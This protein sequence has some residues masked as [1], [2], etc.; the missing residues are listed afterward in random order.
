MF[1]IRADRTQTDELLDAC[2]PRL[3]DELYPHDGVVIEETPRMKPVRTDSAYDGRCMDHHV[4]TLLG[5]K[6]PNGGRV[7]KV[8]LLRR[9]GKN[10]R[11]FSTS[12]SVLNEA[13]QEAATSRQEDA[14]VPPE[15]LASG[16][17]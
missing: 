2:Q 1:R 16:N 13:S 17:Q 11:R 8:E 15:L 7:A 9:R 5:K 12:E 10:L 4:R 14:A 3:L 6:L